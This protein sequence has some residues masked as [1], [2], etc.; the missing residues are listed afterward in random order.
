MR[1]NDGIKVVNIATIAQSEDNEDL[2]FDNVNNENAEIKEVES[3][4]EE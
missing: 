2:P 1:F 3:N 4:D